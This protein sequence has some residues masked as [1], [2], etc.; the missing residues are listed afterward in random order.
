MYFKTNLKNV[1]PLLKLFSLSNFSSECLA[2]KFYQISD[3]LNNALKELS[4]TN[5]KNSW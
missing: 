5:L 2:L 4:F 1:L 3:I